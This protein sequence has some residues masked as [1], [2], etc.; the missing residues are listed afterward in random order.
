MTPESAANG[1]VPRNTPVRSALLGIWLSGSISRIAKLL[2]VGGGSGAYSIAFCAAN[3]HLRATI[4]D[5]PET[6]DTAKL[7]AR[8]AGFSDRIAHLAGNAVK[9]EWPD[10][11]DIVLLE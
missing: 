10:G 7:Y 11:H 9:V 5:F 6:M 8:E 4:L 1:S 3:Q 2:D